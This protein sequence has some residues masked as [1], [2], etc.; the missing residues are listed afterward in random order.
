MGL[1]AEPLFVRIAAASG[2]DSVIIIII[3]NY[4]NR[5]D[6]GGYAE[7]CDKD[8]GGA[9]EIFAFSGGG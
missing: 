1:Q 4:D 9:F 6:D 5:S 2:A 8:T 3:G 7:Y